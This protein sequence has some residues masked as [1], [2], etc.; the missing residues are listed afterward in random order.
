M[1]ESNGSGQLKIGGALTFS[2]LA[3]WTVRAELEAGLQ[4]LGY[5]SYLPEPRSAAACLRD[6]LGEV[7]HE[8][9]VEIKNLAKAGSFEVIRVAKGEH[10]NSYDHLYRVGVDD[11]RQ[12]SLYPFIPDTADKIASEFNQQLGLLRC[13]AVTECLKS[14]LN[15]LGGTSLRPRGAL[16]WVPPHQVSLWEQIG[17]VVDATGYKKP[18]TVYLFRH[19]M[20]AQALRGVRD[21]IL[22]EV[23]Q[24][25]AEIKQ[26]V[27]DPDNP[28]KARALAHRQEEARELREKVHLYEELLGVGLSTLS[29]TLDEVETTIGQAAL[30][31]ASAVE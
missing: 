26:E 12:I 19:T 25:S 20:D 28:L 22:R 24:R 10:R 17:A 14:I 27:L 23:Q 6:A 9:S 16:Y 7:F 21:G 2:A 8:T 15:S 13:Y 31:T 29:R 5:L 11:Q 30:L 1:S 18:S 3:E 4:R